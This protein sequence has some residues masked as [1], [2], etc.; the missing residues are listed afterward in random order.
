MVGTSSGSVIRIACA[1]A[2]TLAVSGATLAQTANPLQRED[3]RRPSGARVTSETGPNA[4]KL[5][6]SD[7]ERLHDAFQPRGIEL[8]QFLMLP[9]VELDT[10]FTD[11]LYATERNAKSEMVGIARTEVRARSR[12][13]VHMLNLSAN[14]DARRHATYSR[15][16]AVD[17]RVGFDGRY[18]LSRTDEVTGLFDLAYRHEDRGSPDDAGGLKPTPTLAV[19]GRTGAKFDFGRISL[20]PSVTAVRRTYDDV[21]AAGG[22]T[23]NNSDRDRV[24]LEGQMAVYNEVFAGYAVVLAATA[25]SRRYDDTVDDLGF[26]RSSTG[27]RLETGVGVDLTNILR[28]EFLVGY[29]KQDYEDRRFGEQAG[30]TVRAS[31]NWTPTTLTLVVP[32]LARTIEETTLANA[33]GTVRTTASVLV[34]HEYARNVLLTGTVSF[35]QDVFEG[36]NRTDDNYEARGRVTYAL[37]PE[38]HVSSELRYRIRESNTVNNSYD[39]ATILFRLGLQL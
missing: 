9:K 37:M 29:Q 16:D 14:V 6:D 20:R 31:F 28:G 36:V 11:N 32:S 22:R 18:D 23:I 27:W 8:G 39:Q 19:T 24:E 34:R 1:V 15:D 4:E 2:A 25:N 10:V 21:T 38:V 30:P 5:G 12:M 7:T 26:R 35:F 13:P 3:Q 17:G 33:S